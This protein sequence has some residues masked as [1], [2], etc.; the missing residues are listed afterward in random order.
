MSNR[1]PTFG[2]RYERFLQDVIG[3]PDDWYD[4]EPEEFFDPYENWK[5]SLHEPDGYYGPSRPSVEMSDWYRRALTEEL[6]HF[7]PVWHNNEII[8]LRLTLEQV[9]QGLIP[10]SDFSLLEN[11]WHAYRICVRCVYSD[12]HKIET[13]TQVHYLGEKFDRSLEVVTNLEFDFSTAS[14]G[15][16]P[17]PA[18]TLCG[19][20]YELVPYPF[21]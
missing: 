6:G 7:D 20:V 9:H 12:Y 2:D 21:H 19:F 13:E 10:G 8:Q 15:D 3:H 18:A 5:L 4:E 1:F 17:S 16:L 11:L 14:F